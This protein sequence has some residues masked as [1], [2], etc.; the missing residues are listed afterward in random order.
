VDGSP[1]EER[2]QTTALVRGGHEFPDVMCGPV[3]AADRAVLAGHDERRKS[4][5]SRGRGPWTPGAEDSGKL[6]SM[7]N[8]CLT[9]EA[10]PACD[11]NSCAT[12]E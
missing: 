9:L 11:W 1:E 2:P 4:W 12:I 3:A 8:R 6:F 5:F 7:V 10:Q